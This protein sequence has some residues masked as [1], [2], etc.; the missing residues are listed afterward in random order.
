MGRKTTVWI[1]QAT[2]KQNLTQDLGT[3]LRKGN[4]KRETKFLSIATQNYVKDQLC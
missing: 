3:C 2:N 4:L 1:F